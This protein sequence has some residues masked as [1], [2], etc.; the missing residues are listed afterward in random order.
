MGLNN[1]D[2]FNKRNIETLLNVDKMFS[3]FRCDTISYA[4]RNYIL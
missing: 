1:F 3:T 4:R 2:T